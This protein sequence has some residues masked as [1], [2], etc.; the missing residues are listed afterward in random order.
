M[1]KIYFLLALVFVFLNVSAQAQCTPDSVNFPKDSLITPATLSA[2]A[3]VTYNQT[4]QFRF[5]KDTTITQSGFTASVHV[6][7]VT[8]DSVRNFPSSFNYQCGNKTCTYRGGQYGCV[9]ITG[10]PTSSQIGNYK[11][12]VYF[13]AY[14]TGTSGILTGSHFTFPDSGKVTLSI[15][16]NTGI[17]NQPVNTSFELA[18]NYPNP[19]NS[20]TEIS[21]NSPDIQPAYLIVRNELGQ[22]VYNKEIHAVQG[23]NI[24]NFNRSSLPQGMYFYSIQSGNN[25]ITRR[26]V[27]KD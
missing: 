18:Q 22:Q 20:N 21:F 11:L 7:S 14:L 9:L 24:L 16:H 8:F 2:T 27:I 10:S 5:P 4:V 1:K 15:T 23:F 19:F 12:E 25:I 26:M 3:G 6:D 17:F 13:I